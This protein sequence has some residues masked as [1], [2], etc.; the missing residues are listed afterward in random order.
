MPVGRRPRDGGSFLKENRASVGRGYR[1]ST[2]TSFE[3]AY[4]HQLQWATISGRTRNALQ[5][6]VAVAVASRVAVARYNCRALVRPEG[7]EALLD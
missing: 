3:M 2:R 6:R 4:R 1:L 5:L 7:R